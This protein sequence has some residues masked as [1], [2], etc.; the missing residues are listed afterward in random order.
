MKYRNLIVVSRLLSAVFRLYYMPIVGFVALFT[1]TSLRLLPWFYK[2]TVLCMVYVFTIFLPR[3]CI[4]V[5]RKLNGWGLIQLRVREY[6]AVPYILF[7]LSYLAFLVLM[8]R[9]HMP[10]YICGILVSALLIQMVC[11]TVNVW[12]KISMHSAG[13][14]GV[15]G[16]LLAYSFLFD[17]NPVGWLCAMILIAGA[18]GSARML[19]RQHSLEQI[20]VGT[21]VGVI[22]GFAG[23]ILL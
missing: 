2:L 9:L 3:L 22:C 14:G 12:W 23:I 8:F 18:V 1:F 19:L 6:R 20:I 10:R 11:V 15:I 4:L 16:A 17:F 13:A 5:W 21:L 7:I